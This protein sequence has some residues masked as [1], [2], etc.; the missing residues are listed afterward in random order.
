MRTT[1]K[2]GRQ[3]GRLCRL[4]T[5]RT[6]PHKGIPESPSNWCETGPTHGRLRELIGLASP[7]CFATWGNC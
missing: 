5:A 7:V 3:A 1:P 2:A 4:T 6:G